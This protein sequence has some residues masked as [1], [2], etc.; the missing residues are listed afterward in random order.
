MKTRIFLA[1]AFATVIA[2]SLSAVAQS[3]PQTTMTV[4]PLAAAPAFTFH[5]LRRRSG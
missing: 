3:N 5:P 4:A 2:S 1:V